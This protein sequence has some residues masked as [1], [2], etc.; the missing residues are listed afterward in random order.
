[1]SVNRVIGT[2]GWVDPKTLPKGA[3]GRP[4]CR[5]CNGEIPKRRRTF[6]SAECVHE[7]KLRSDPSYVRSELFK[8]DK[9][10]CATCGRSAR[11]LNAKLHRWKKWDRIYCTRF[12][13]PLKWSSSWSSG[14]KKFLATRRERLFKRIGLEWLLH[15]KSFWDADHILPVAKGGGECGLDNYQTLCCFCHREKTFLKPSAPQN[16]K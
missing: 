4:L 14:R 12:P 15:R 13:K 9:G 10:R 3:N 7:H 2:R 6:C 16:Y 1:M 8:R 5:F 11:V